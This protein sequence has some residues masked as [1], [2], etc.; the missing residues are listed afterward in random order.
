MGGWVKS[1]M[2]ALF[3]SSRTKRVLKDIL[4]EYK[5]RSEVDAGDFG[6]FHKDSSWQVSTMEHI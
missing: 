5:W 4:S 3:E 1:I 6:S 2:R